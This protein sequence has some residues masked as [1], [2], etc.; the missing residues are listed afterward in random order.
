MHVENQLIKTLFRLS[1]PAP[2]GRKKP[3]ANHQHL[4]ETG[5]L[6]Q[7]AAQKKQMIRSMKKNPRLQPQHAIHYRHVVGTYMSN[8][9]DKGRSHTD[10]AVIDENSNTHKNLPELVM[11]VVT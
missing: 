5:K 6:T 8:V 10:D 2:T 9:V 11:E 1:F 7:H 4:A 3:A